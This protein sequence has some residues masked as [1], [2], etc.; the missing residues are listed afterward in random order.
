[1]SPQCGHRQPLSSFA[2]S[3]LTAG[4]AINIH[5]VAKLCGALGLV[6]SC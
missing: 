4:G 3:A 6:G 1:M 5:G 2:Y